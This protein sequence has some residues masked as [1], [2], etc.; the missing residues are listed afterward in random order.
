[1]QKPPLK[2]KEKVLFL[3]QVH[4]LTAE[5]MGSGPTDPDH[6]ALLCHTASR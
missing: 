1:M 5:G 6:A 4:I 2:V 3:D